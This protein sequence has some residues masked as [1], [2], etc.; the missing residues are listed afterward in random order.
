[1]PTEAA[2]DLRVLIL[3]PI[4][5][6][7]A[8]T[9]Q[10][11]A[12][13]GMP[14]HVCANARELCQANPARRGRGAPDRGGAGRPRTSTSWRRRCRPSRPGRTCRCC[15]FAG[16]DWSQ[17]TI[18]TLRTL[19]VMRNVTLLDR[20]IRRHRRRQHGPRRAA[21]TPPAVR[22]A[23]RARRARVV[24]PGRRAGPRRRGARQPA[25]GRVPGHPVARAAHAA[26]R[27]PRLGVAAARSAASR[28]PASRRCWRSWPATRSRRRS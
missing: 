16:D 20:P 4:G 22:A 9:S 1:M 21:R 13:A 24:A 26:Q 2:V 7:G 10:L 11:L 28:Q 15:S 12:N 14:C 5:R 27:H 25:Q 6:D 3:A 18:R 8:L 23:R 19:E 17:A